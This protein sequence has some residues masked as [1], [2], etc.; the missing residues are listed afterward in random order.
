MREYIKFWGMGTSQIQLFC[1]NMGFL[2]LHMKLKVHYFGSAK[3]SSACM[4][5]NCN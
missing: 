5:I 1:P 3:V 4:P 2:C